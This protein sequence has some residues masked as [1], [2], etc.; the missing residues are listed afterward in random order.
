MKQFKEAE[1]LLHDVIIGNQPED[2]AAQAPAYNTL[3]DCLRVTNR[4]TDALFA[5]LHTDLLYSKSK[6]E[7]PRALHHIVELYRQ[8]K[9]DGHADEVAQRLEARVSTQFLGLCA[10]GRSVDLRILLIPVKFPREGN[11]AAQ[12][13]ACFRLGRSPSAHTVRRCRG[14]AL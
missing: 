6:E 14:K 13:F 8:L 3:G 2:A 4:P 7:H 5:Y 10:V 12:R 1:A 11:H 9:Q